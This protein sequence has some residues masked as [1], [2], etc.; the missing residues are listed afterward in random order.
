M[1]DL[2]MHTVHVPF[3]LGW[4]PKRVYAQLQKVYTERPDGKGGTAVCDTWDNALLHTEVDIDGREVPM[5]FETKRL[6]PGE[7]NSW[8]IEILG[9]DGGVR[10]TTKEP[11]TLWT[12]ARGKEQ[13]WQKNGSRFSWTFSHDHGRHFR[14]GL[15]GLLPANVGG[16]PRRARGQ[17]RRTVSAVRHRTRPCSA[18]ASSPRRCNRTREKRAISL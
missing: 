11:K 10:Y 17:T 13:L 4:K 2:G 1:G 9:T 5:R 3:R 15:P 8:F 7:T 6:A 12:F 16:I 14:A 18:I